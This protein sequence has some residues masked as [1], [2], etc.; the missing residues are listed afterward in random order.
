[1]DGL[2][3]SRRAR[4]SSPDLPREL[5]HA[6]ELALLVVLA[7]E[8]A[9]H[10]RAEAALR[11]YREALERDVLRS[12]FH[13]PRQLVEGFQFGNFGTYDSE[14]HDLVLW[15]EAQRREASGARRVVF[16]EEAA[17]RQ[18]VEEALRDRVVAALAVPHAA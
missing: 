13:L 5:D 17:V 9:D 11:A 1:M 10:V 18:L 2:R 4:T 16:Q 3:P 12:F 7:D 6:L 8:V 15:H 14:H